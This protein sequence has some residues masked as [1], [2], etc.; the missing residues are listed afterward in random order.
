MGVMVV[1]G[2][3]GCFREAEG[4]DWLRVEFRGSRGAW[5]FGRSTP[6]NSPQEIA[7]D[8]W[9]AFD[10]YTFLCYCPDCWAEIHKEE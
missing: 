5:G 3:D 9:V 10:P 4:T 2:C 6:V 8:G 7:P 1:F